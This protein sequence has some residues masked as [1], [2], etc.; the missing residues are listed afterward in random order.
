M[1]KSMA[2]KVVMITGG[3]DGIGLEAAKTL[4]GMGAE[5]V[6]VGRSRERAETAIKEIAAHSQAAAAGYFLADL[7]LMAEVRRL[8][9]E[10]KEKYSRL[11]VLINNAGSAFINRTVTAEGHEKTFALNHLAYF[12]LTNDLLELLKN[13]GKARVV[14]V[15]SGAHLSGR[16]DF[17][18][19]NLENGY[20]V[21]KAY[22]QSKLAN[23][24]F[25]YELARRLDGSGVTANVLHPGLVKTG[26]FR[27]LRWIGPLAD[28]VVRSRERSLSVEEGA[29]TI[30]YLASSPEVEGVTSKYFVKCKAVDSS[31]LSYDVVAQKRLWEE[32]QRQVGE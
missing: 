2:G 23:V 21:L 16:I 17:E 25:T 10:F 32:S 14:N 12:L 8:A 22:R 18:D 3:T 29:Q 26:I 7:S 30:V 24:M 19:L 20:F 31:V 15:S 6:V 1:E 9:E 27:K 5:V 4:A 28:L 11:D 13:S